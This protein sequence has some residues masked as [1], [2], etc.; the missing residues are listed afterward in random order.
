MCL[1]DD[2]EDIVKNIKLLSGAVGSGVK[3]KMDNK[4]DG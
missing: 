1:N 3:E 4:L 2:G